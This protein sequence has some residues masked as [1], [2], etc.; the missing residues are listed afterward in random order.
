MS[1]TKRSA[2]AARARGYAISTSGVIPAACE[3]LKLSAAAA[4]GS[5]SAASTARAASA[6]VLPFT[7][8]SASSKGKRPAPPAASW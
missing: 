1:R 4:Y 5:F 8:P 6:G 3:R 2:A 7:S